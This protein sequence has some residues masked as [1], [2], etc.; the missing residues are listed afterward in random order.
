M[1][2]AAR[3]SFYY[4]YSF[5]VFKAAGV[6]TADKKYVIMPEYPYEVAFDLSADPLEETNLV[7]GT[8][9][10]WV[11]PMRADLFARYGSTLLSGITAGDLAPVS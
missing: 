4:E 6:R 11:G 2:D 5:P 8:A 1:Y 7:G 10:A 9:P 3:A